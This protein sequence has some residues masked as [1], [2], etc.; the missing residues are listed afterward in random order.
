MRRFPDAAS[1]ASGPKLRHLRETLARLGP[2]YGG[3]GIGSDADEPMNVEG[4]SNQVPADGA[5]IRAICS[6]LRR[7]LSRPVTG[8][9]A[10]RPLLS[11]QS[12]VSARFI[13]TVE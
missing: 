11:E 12:E 2:N 4:C 3:P 5:S 10:P 9:R 13:A 1:L 7:H 8:S 6:E